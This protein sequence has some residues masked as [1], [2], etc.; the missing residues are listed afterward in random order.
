MVAAVLRKFRL[1]NID[2]KKKKKKL[3]RYL[4]REFGQVTV[5]QNY[6]SLKL[7]SKLLQCSVFHCKAFSCFYN[8]VRCAL[9]NKC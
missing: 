1:N 8:M 6:N 9:C 7:L 2:E 3:I 4:N 5:F